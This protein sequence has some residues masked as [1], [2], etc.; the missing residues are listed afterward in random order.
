MAAGADLDRVHII[1]AVR[2]PGRGGNRPFNL[3]TDIELLERKIAEI[4][5]VGIVNI[6]PVSSYLGKIDSH[7]NSEVRSVLEP[8]S[9]MAD[10][11]R[12]AI[13]SVTHFSKTGANNTQKALHR[14][15]GSIAFTGAPRAA[16]AVIEDP[17]DTTRRLFLF[18][19][20]N[21][22]APPQGL[23]F[24]V[25]QTIVADSIVA[26]RVAW[27][28]EPVSITANQALAAEAAGTEH[29]S[30]QAEAE[31]FLSDLLANGPVPQKDIEADTKGAGLSWRTVR[32]AKARLGV[33]AQRQ[34]EGKSGAG[35]WV[36]SL[37][38]GQ[39]APRC[40]RLK[41]GHL[42][43]NGHLADEDENAMQ[44]AGDAA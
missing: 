27:E 37:Q 19:K 40:P 13:L 1:S 12:V 15:I 3:Q 16:F 22:A 8:L 41:R 38:D 11:T 30:A 14:F 4:G 32:R 20:G 21:L 26:S 44:G 23:A 29:Q 17:E 18:A 34:S 10:R 31:E 43:E 42:A 35:R 25:E 9:E 33:S 7:K 39:D 24:R 5:E 6:D 28:T 36:W 2:N